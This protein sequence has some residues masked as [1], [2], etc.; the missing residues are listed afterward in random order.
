MKL[1]NRVNTAT[2][3]GKNLLYFRPKYGWWRGG[4]IPSGPPA[5]AG[6]GDP[7][8]PRTVQN[9]FCQGIPNLML[10]R[11][12]KNPPMRRDGAGGRG[13]I[14]AAIGFWWKG[15]FYEGVYFRA[16]IEYKYGMMLHE[17]DLLYRV[18]RNLKD[19]GHVAYVLEDGTNPTLLQSQPSKGSLEPGVHTDKRVYNQRRYYHYVVRAKD[20]LM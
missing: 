15:D 2:K 16:A 17:G 9:I 20:W 14:G 3:Y 10:R 11:V 18:Y 12:G 4:N 8:L 6:L 1:A 19:Q 7:P 5:Y 13:G